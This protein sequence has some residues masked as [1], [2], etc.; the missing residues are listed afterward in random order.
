M[1]VRSRLTS[2]AA[3]AALAV[4]LA[5]TAQSA[6]GASPTPVPSASA[7]STAP[8]TAST[9]ATPATPAL[10]M[11]LGGTYSDW[12]G[13]SKRLSSSF[14]STSWASA[15]DG[16]GCTLISATPSDF[17]SNGSPVYG[18]IPAGI[19]IPAETFVAQCDNGG[20]PAFQAHIPSARALSASLAT[21]QV[22]TPAATAG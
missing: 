16:Y 3:A 1:R 12:V 7:A 5:G 18:G 17:T 15:V 20:V 11:P 10:A 2:L 8:V 13:W 21:P 6:Y 19:V 14:H 22:T 4:S 9:P